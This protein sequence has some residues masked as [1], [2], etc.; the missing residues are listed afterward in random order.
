MKE[1]ANYSY[2]G[3]RGITVCRGWRESFD[4]FLRDM[5]ESPAHKSLDRIDNNR[6]YWCGHCDE[7]IANERQTNCHWAT[8]EEQGRN[9][10]NNRL[11]T[12]NSETRTATEWAKRFGV[13]YNRVMNRIYRG[14]YPV[15]LI[16]K[17]TKLEWGE[18]KDATFSKQG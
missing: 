5:G 15:D 17:P 10:R 11:L 4:S 16:F 3:G 2:Y 6:G 14:G 9:K 18:R 8:R 12:V 13:P 7:C 1:A